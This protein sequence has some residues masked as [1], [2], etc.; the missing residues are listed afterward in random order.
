MGKRLYGTV[1]TFPQYGFYL[2]AT[3]LQQIPHL[4]WKTDKP[5]WVNQWPLPRENLLQMNT[6]TEEQLVAGHIV[7]TTSP[8]N[9]PIFCYLKSDLGSGDWYMISEK[10]TQLLKT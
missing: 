10:L 8:W 5:V 9:S 3:A 2:G 7:P 6:L 1:G 4:R